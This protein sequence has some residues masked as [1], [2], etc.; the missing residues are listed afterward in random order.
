MGLWWWAAESSS[1]LSTNDEPAE[2]PQRSLDGLSSLFSYT[3]FQQ[4]LTLSPSWQW[5]ALNRH[6]YFYRVHMKQLIIWYN[7]W[8][9]K[10]VCK[11]KE[12]RVILMSPPSILGHFL[13][14]IFYWSIIALQC[15]VSVCCTMKWISLYIY[16]LPPGPPPMPIPHP[17]RSS[18]ST[19]LRSLCYTEALH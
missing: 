12:E 13:L 5:A 9:W 17:S 14:F 15:W 2:S 18:Q 3:S 6:G 7:W 19:E 4:A 11:R 10:Q 1:M 8:M 16:S